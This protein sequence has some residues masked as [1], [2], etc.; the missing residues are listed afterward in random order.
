MG[1]AP[2]GFG[3]GKIILLGEH[4]VV[5]GRPALAAGI[6]R[7]VVTTAEPAEVSSLHIAPWGVDVRGGGSEPLERAF[8]ALL[9]SYE[10]PPSVRVRA[11]VALPAGAGLGCSAALGVAIV[12]AIDRALG[13]ERDAS[14]RAEASMTWERVF[15]GNP[16]G[17]DSTM[18]A[19]GGVAVFR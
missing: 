7:G 14:G 4:G 5:Y 6:E 15:H 17:V 10:T 19:L 1:L 12:E 8:E 16:S 11:E 3:R 2:M 9:A 13:I 18:A